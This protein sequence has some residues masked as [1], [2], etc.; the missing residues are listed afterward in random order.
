ML[1][2]YLKY[3]LIMLFITSLACSSTEPFDNGV[4]YRYKADKLLQETFKPEIWREFTQYLTSAEWFNQVIKTFEPWVP[5]SLH[6]KYTEEDLGARGWADNKNIWTDCQ[7]VMHKPITEKTTRTPHLDNPMEIFAGLLYFPHED[8]SGTGGEFQIHS[9]KG[10]ITE[11]NKLTGGRCHYFN[12]NAAAEETMDKFLPQ[13][14]EITGEEPIKLLLHSIAFGTTTNFFGKKPVTQRQMDMTVHVMGNALL[15]WTQKL[16]A[17]G[18]LGE[19]SRVMGLTSEGNYLAME[20]YGPVSVAK[21][22]ME[23][24]IR[25]IGWELGQYGI[26]ANAVQAGIT[27]TR[28]LTKITDRW[29]DWV[30][31]TKSRNPMRR[32]TTPE[33]VAGTISMLL[34]PE[35]DFINCSIIYCDG[36]EHRSGSI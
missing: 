6:K 8:D 7:L 4:C 35:A 23:A 1:E 12:T 2:S 9:S 27:P 20:G 17:E 22:A 11:V 10:T 15:Y 33:D 26:T 25:Q 5:A 13:I 31:G 18:L 28:A 32:T 14:K 3:F 29:E 16:F 24:I 36:G 19:G 34:K 30:E 21:V